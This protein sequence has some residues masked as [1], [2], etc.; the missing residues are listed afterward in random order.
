LK[1]ESGQVAIFVI[2]LSLVVFAVVGIAV[3][4]TRAFL[5][6]RALQNAADGAA[7]GA[8]ARIDTGAY[9]SGAPLHLD[10]DAARRSVGATLARRGISASVSLDAAPEG[11]TI[12]LRHRVDTTFLALVGI[13]SLPV[14]VEAV[15]EPRPLP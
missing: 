13:S 15:A 8:A 6:R 1:P 14:A 12:L 9:Y 2:G 11:V 7:A 5:Y 3:D 10:T 4:G